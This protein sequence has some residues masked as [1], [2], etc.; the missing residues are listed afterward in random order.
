[1]NAGLYP[2]PFYFIQAV[3]IPAN[4]TIPHPVLRVGENKVKQVKMIA[5]SLILLR[6]SQNCRGWKSPQEIIKS[7]PC[8][9]RYPTIVRTGQ[10]PDGS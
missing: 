5:K 10:R 7:N 2:L 6:E 8:S 3:T 1:M 9:S 4:A